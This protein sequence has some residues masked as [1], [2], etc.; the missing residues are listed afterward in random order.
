VSARLASDDDAWRQVAEQFGTQLQR[1]RHALGLTQAAVAAL[2]G[3]SRYVYQ[4]YERGQGRPGAPVNP[5]LRTLVALAQALDTTV[6][7]LIPKNMPDF[8]HR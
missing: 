5:Q 1:R 8:T 2:A 3:M 7:D 6:G 4:K